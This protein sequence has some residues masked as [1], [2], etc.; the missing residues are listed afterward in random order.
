MTL[1]LN[2]ILGG[3]AWLYQTYGL[4]KQ[5]P[6]PHFPYILQNFWF[7]HWCLWSFRVLWNA[8]PG[9]LINRYRSF[10]GP[11]YQSTRRNLQ[12]HCFLCDVRSRYLPN[13]ECPFCRVPCHGS[14]VAASPGNL[15]PVST[16]QYSGP[17]IA[18]YRDYLI[19]CRTLTSFVINFHSHG[20]NNMYNV[21]DTEIN[22]SSFS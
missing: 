1:V 3:S 16:L 8:S 10:E 13:A 4:W 2:R 14:F 19:S 6:E 11:C 9:R 21:L 12:Q 22:V 18:G 7:S 15:E 17:S 20:H 5:L